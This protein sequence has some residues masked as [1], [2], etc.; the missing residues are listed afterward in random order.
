MKGDSQLFFIVS[1]SSSLSYTPEGDT[2][3]EGGRD[4]KKEREGGRDR[5]KERIKIWD[6]QRGGTEVQS[7]TGI[8]E[9]EHK[10]RE[11]LLLEE[12]HKD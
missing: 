4:R 8:I 5:K 6:L 3:R 10:T 1:F 2:E 11:E 7:E 12:R 9:L